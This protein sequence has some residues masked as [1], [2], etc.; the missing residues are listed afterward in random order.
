M[1]SNV[2]TSG[3][4]E[5]RYFARAWAL[6]THEKGWW[7]PVLICMVASLVPIVGPMAVLGYLVEWSRRIAWGGTEGPSRRVKVGDLLRSGWRAFVVI[8]GWGIASWVVTSVIGKVSSGF[9]YEVLSFVWTVISVFLSMVFMV[10]AVRAT[11]YQSFVAGYRMPTLWKMAT[12]DPVGLVRIWF[13]KVASYV[14]DFVV[15]LAVTAATFFSSFGWIYRFVQYVEEYS[16]FYAQYYGS[17]FSA[18]VIG[19]LVVRFW[20]ALLLI[21]VL[22]MVIGVFAKFLVYAALG[23]WLRRFDVPRW[24]RDEDPLPERMIAEKPQLEAPVPPSE[25][26]QPAPVRQPSPVQQEM[27]AQAARPVQQPSPVQTTAPAQPAAPVAQEESVRAAPA[28]RAQQPAP[29]Q[30]SVQ[31]VAPAETTVSPAPTQV[32]Q[33]VASSQPAEPSE[34]VTAPEASAPAATVEPSSVVT[35]SA[36][37]SVDPLAQVVSVEPIAVAPIE[38]PASAAT[39]ATSDDAP[40]A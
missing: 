12:E 34:S 1:A 19:A 4:Q 40:S 29:T 9:V 38:A 21:F 37:E 35:P 32:P 28:A 6:L 31:P 30:A 17:S 24:G 7:K 39:D 3:Y 18:E 26:V 10:A 15:A 11:I 2:D 14:I 33:V 36:A 23:L 20:P 27:P 13:I 5:G 16:S 8:G 22:V 25:P